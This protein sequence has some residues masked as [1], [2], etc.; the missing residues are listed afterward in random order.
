MPGP[1]RFLGVCI[2][3]ALALPASLQAQGNDRF[4]RALEDFS[5]A[6]AGT[7][8][9]EGPGLVAA[10]DEMQAGLLEWDALIANL[11]SRFGSEVGS[12]P[13]PA[14]ARMR[15]ALGTV[16]LE[17]GR[18]QDAIGQFDRAVTLDPQFAD[19]HL[20][21]GLAF[22]L[23]NRV[24]ESA[25]AYRSL[26]QRD[27]RNPAHAYLFLRSTAEAGV[28]AA[29]ARQ[30]LQ[31]AVE[32]PSRS[33]RTALFVALGLV[34]DGAVV[35]PVFPP[36]AYTAGF[37]GVRARQ[38]DSAVAALRA[39]TASDP[40]VSDPGLRDPAARDLIAAVRRAEAGAVAMLAEAAAR[41]ASGELHRIAG[42][43][44]FGVRQHDESL[45]Q[46]RR[47]VRL[48]PS[49]ERAR[50]AMADVL[51]EAG[52]PAGARAVL[53]ETAKAL[54][55]S[56]LARWKLGRLSQLMGD[57]RGALQA[58]EAAADL[59]ALA[60]TGHLYSAIGR[61]QHNQL[62]LDAAAAAY[63]RRVAVAPNDSAAHYDLGE[64][65]RAQGRLDAALTE[66]LTAALL[67]PAS[68]RA[69]AAIGQIHADSGRDTEAVAMLRRATD[70][71]ATHLESRYALSR[72]LMR[73]GRVD[74]A[75]KELEIFEKLQS[76]AMDDE[77][78][79]YKENQMKIDEA[80]KSGDRSGAGR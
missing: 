12:A 39:A 29:N 80:L 38:Y 35:A 63:A 4:V 66:F 30:V 64:V 48:N 10:L 72:A 31:A 42:L 26:W 65:H 78:R 73:L 32:Q 22:E 3:L 68:A 11:E 8:G 51:V 52:D 43:A 33:D 36:A 54:P 77:R 70:L 45:E 15:T 62:N 40:L 58:F 16:Y 49:D 14:A 19:V 67:D 71:D 21:R 2:V 41:L 50:I 25:D 6:M 17:R 69:F 7:H 9:D 37:A 53:V 18:V 13:A 75:R 28:D 27:P 55:A 24:P 60:G 56:G 79:R 23:V 59:P 61:L 34:D 57:E 76:R 1:R 74:E 44:Y 46:L 20:L 47:A 5:N